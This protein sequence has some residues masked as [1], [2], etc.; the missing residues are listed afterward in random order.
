MK[1]SETE[2]KMPFGKYKGMTLFEIKNLDKPYLEWL[3][4]NAEENNIDTDT[5]FYI[6]NLILNG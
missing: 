4:R 6:E 2:F 1:Q 5:K 3:Y